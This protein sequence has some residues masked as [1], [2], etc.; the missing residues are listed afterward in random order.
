MPKSGN[1]VGSRSWGG[2]VNKLWKGDELWEADELGVA[3]SWAG[4]QR[5]RWVMLARGGR[6]A[7]GR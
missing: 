2:I 4:G 6:R 1:A 7:S 3:G 5:W